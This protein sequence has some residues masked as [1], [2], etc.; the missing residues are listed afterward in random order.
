MSVLDA[1]ALLAFLNEEPGAEVVEHHL[2]E[3]SVLS[4]ANWSEVV[5]KVE[6]RHGDIHLVK[7]LLQGYGT[8]I[9]PVTR[10]DAEAAARLW[11]AMKHLSLGDRLCLATGARLQ[12]VVVTADAAWGESEAVV[13]IR[14]QNGA[15]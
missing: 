12:R 1:S 13:Q 15:A 9:E 5:Q 6:S 10:E 7:A 14:R 4:A 11:P 2:D 8:Q 3:G